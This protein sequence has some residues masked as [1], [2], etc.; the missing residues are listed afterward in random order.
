MFPKAKKAK[1]DLMELGEQIS[2]RKQELQAE[3]SGFE[4]GEG[5][6]SHAA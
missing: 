6:R 2:R 3:L 1:V 4:S 5:R